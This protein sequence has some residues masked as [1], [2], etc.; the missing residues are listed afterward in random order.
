MASN[1]NK[2]EAANVTTP[3]AVDKAESS[4]TTNVI[5]G[6]NQPVDSAVI[7]GDTASPVVPPKSNDQYDVINGGV[8]IET[9]VL[10]A[11]GVRHLL[12]CTLVSHPGHFYVKFVNAAYDTALANMKSFY[13]SDE[14]ID[15]SVDVLKSGQYFAAARLKAGSSD[16]EKEWIRVQL[17]H[18]E[19]AD[20]I[21][22][23]L[24]DQGCFGVFK[25][26]D[27]QPLYN[28]FRSVPKQAIRAS[29]SGM[30]CSF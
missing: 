12:E 4:Q 1:G 9:P 23:L 3:T 10:P 21:N 8:P 29:L 13:N 7:N 28:Q 27:L 5:N 17:L 20:L 24:I 19:S 26:A 22:C 16:P 14:H 15:L 11:E 30:S 25:I 18:V 6:N 2:E